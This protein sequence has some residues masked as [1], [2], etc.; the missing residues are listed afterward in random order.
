L[1][2]A[3]VGGV[4]DPEAVLTRTPGN[5]RREPLSLVPGGDA[6]R[7]TPSRRLL[8][9][10]SVL[11]PVLWAET[12]AGLASPPARPI[13]DARQLA[14]A[15]ALL[16]PALGPPPGKLKVTLRARPRTSNLDGEAR[17]ARGRLL[18]RFGLRTVDGKL[19]LSRVRALWPSS[20]QLRPLG[21]AK[22]RV[23]AQGLAAALY[24]QWKGH[25]MVL[26]QPTTT[27]FGPIAPG[28]RIP[29]LAYEFGWVDTLKVG[30]QT[31]NWVTVLIDAGTGKLGEYSASY[32]DLPLK[33]PTVWEEQARAVAGAEVRRR[34]PRAARAS[35]SLVRS[36][37]TLGGPRAAP[38]WYFEYDWT[39]PAPKGMRPVSAGDSISVNALTGALIR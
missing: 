6:V 18:A 27:R 15:R 10:A 5:S 4:S 3:V 23:V 11:G 2:V 28:Q 37:C 8:L 1:P 16:S 7:T 34:A 24:P 35:L 9:V 31:R 30:Y 20:A 32:A 39:I 38:V 29:R 33:Y 22:G 36:H 21:L 12:T 14:A 25:H 17:D 13:N 26:A 19:A